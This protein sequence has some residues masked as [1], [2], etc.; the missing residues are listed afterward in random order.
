MR[1]PTRQ[2]PAPPAPVDEGARADAVVAG[3]AVKAGWS[4]VVFAVLLVLSLVLVATTPR[5]GASDAE[6]TTFYSGGGPETLTVVGLY[7]V[8]FAGI[9]CLW[10]MI[11]TRTLLQVRRPNSW[12]DTSHWLH[13]AASVIFVCL[14]FV[15]TAAVGAVSL[16]TKFSDAPLPGPDVARAL[17]SVGYTLL[18]V[19]GVR[20]AGMYMITTTGLASSAGVIPRP[21]VVLSYVVAAL[22][23]VSTTFHPAILRVFP[24]WVL[25]VSIVLLVRRPTGVSP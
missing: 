17:S 16:L 19:Y 6:Y 21:L 20:A 23:L 13:L 22:L 15:S 10:H 12:A 18:F 2:R 4:G 8:P 1:V 5:L 7:I 14:L 9:A 25:M 24:A 3:Y 11:T